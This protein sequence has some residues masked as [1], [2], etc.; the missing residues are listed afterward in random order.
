MVIFPTLA[1]KQIESFRRPFFPVKKHDY[2]IAK[3]RSQ[4]KLWNQWILISFKACS[5]L[6]CGKRLE[7]YE[8]LWREATTAFARDEP[9]LDPQLNDKSKDPRRGVTLLIRPSP[10]VQ[11]QIRSLLDALASVCPRQYFYQPEELHVTVLSIISGT[12]RWQEEMAKLPALRSII[13]EVLADQPPFHIKFCGITAS[14]GSVMIQGFP[15]G[16]GLANIR[17]RLREAFAQKGFGGMLD[18]RYKISGAHIT[19]MRFRQPG[20]DWKHLLP[21]LEENRQTDFGGMEVDRLQLIFGDWYASSNV[22][23][24]LEEYRLEA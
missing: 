24:M 20:L 23:Q 21:L 3:S 2:I 1:G 14:P 5:P 10:A 4:L 22:V 13:S 19:V 15:T 8:K 12:E 6:F 17:G 16:D 9:Q 18:R 7:I 11:K